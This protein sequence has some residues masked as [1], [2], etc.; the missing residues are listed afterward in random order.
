MRALTTLHMWTA[1][2]LA[3]FDHMWT[4]G[5]R[6]PH[7]GVVYGKSFI[8]LFGREFFFWFVL[9]SH[10][11]IS[12]KVQDIVVSNVGLSYLPD[13]G[14]IIYQGNAGPNTATYFAYYDSVTPL[15][16]NNDPTKYTYIIYPASYGDLSS[17]IQNGATPVLGAFTKVGDY[18][19]TN[20]YSISEL[21][22]V[23]RSNALGAFSNA[24]TLAI[25]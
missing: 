10:R 9:E 25:T 16:T 15:S 1:G 17:I 4:A 2:G 8:M 3:T 11:S 19:I 12:L 14:D 5:F 24:T 18:T 21:V 7:M 22:R 23:Y 13:A 6:C 20:D